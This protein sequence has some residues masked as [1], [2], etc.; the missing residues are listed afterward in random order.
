[1]IKFEWNTVKAVTN[2]KK[3]GVSFE[4]AKS[5]FFDDFALQFFDQENSDTEDRF[6]MLGISNE[7][8]ILLICHCERDDGNTIRLISARKATKNES[9]NYQ[10]VH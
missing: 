6:L 2:V 7:T 8:N 10:R 4:E 1:M 5:V 3:H 9:K